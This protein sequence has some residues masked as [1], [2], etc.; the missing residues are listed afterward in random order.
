MVLKGA[1]RCRALYGAYSHH[2][3][4]PSGSDILQYLYLAE[5]VPYISA[6]DKPEIY[7]QSGLISS[8]KA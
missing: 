8:M 6:A 3:S 4:S 1:G 2:L 7:Q 5:R